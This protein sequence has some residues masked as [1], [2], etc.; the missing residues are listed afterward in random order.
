MMTVCPH[1]VYRT[2]RLSS[3]TLLILTLLLG[4]ASAQES[5]TF[6][7]CSSQ[8]LDEYDTIEATCLKTPSACCSKEEGDHT[9]LCAVRE[10][11]DD[12]GC[13]IR[14][15]GSSNGAGLVVMDTIGVSGGLKSAGAGGECSRDAFVDGSELCTRCAVA[16][17]DSGK[18]MD[19]ENVAV[20]GADETFTPPAVCAED[21]VADTT[22]DGT[23]SP[24]IADA[25]R[26]P[27]VTATDAVENASAE[28]V[29]DASA[30]NEAPDETPD[31]TSQME[32]DAASCF[33][34]DNEVQLESGDVVRM[35]RLIVGD[36]VHVGYG[37][38]SS[39]YMF[40]HKIAYHQGAFLRIETASGLITKMTPGHFVYANGA[41]VA[42]GALSVGDAMEDSEGRAQVVKSLDI[43]SGTGLYNPQ[44][45]QGDVVVD[46]LRVSTYTEAVRPEV[47]HALLSPLRTAY[48]LLGWSTSGL[49][50]EH[51]SI[52]HARALFF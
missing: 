3:T 30:E 14:S 42:A 22:G 31:Q 7:Q 39:I 49:D 6:P 35:D 41:L 48:E 1:L 47:A 32:S 9:I 33:S 16:Y 28:A 45:I 38:F 27:P 26:N 36:R 25:T 19:C 40:T 44:T 4:T 34:G 12:V 50:G 15:V 8:E 51:G 5:G 17:D 20:P 23:T 29:E 11:V 37:K 52:E 13:C 2:P 10:G 21:K 43:V 46:G 18:G 24:T